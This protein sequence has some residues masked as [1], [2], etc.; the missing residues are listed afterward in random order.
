LSYAENLL[1]LVFAEASDQYGI[2]YDYGWVAETSAFAEDVRANFLLVHF[3]TQIN[4]HILVFDVIVFQVLL[5]HFA[6]YAGA[7]SVH[8]N[9]VFA[10]FA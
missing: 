9:F 3:I 8:E 6:P 10:V 5:G 1:E 2:V 4:I 7:E